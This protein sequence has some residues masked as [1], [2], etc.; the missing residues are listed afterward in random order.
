[1]KRFILFLFLWTIF[2]CGC[3]PQP[4]KIEI[5]RTRSFQDNKLIIT[6]RNNGQAVTTTIKNLDEAKQYKGHLNSIIKDIEE[7]EKELSSQDK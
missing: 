6:H 4:Q 7:Y 3:E 5:T 2:I 1:M